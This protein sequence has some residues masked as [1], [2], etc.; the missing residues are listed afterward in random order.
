MTLAR[1]T[2][3]PAV[4]LAALA[5]AA[6]LAHGWRRAAIAFAAGAV[7]VLALAPFDLWPLAF[8]TFPFLVWLIDGAAAG[9]YGSIG[10]AGIIGWWF[11]F[12]YFLAGLYWIGNAL[13]VDAAT[14]G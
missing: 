5:H 13:L 10:T 1:R 11:G 8:L 4:T 9:R 2:V 12:G 7:S 6:M 3:A 14:F